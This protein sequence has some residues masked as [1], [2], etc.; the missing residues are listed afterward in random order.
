MNKILEQKMLTIADSLG[1][2]IAVKDEPFTLAG[3]GHKVVHYKGRNIPIRFMI[4]GTLLLPENNVGVVV[5][6]D[7]WDYNLLLY[8]KEDTIYLV[9]YTGKINCK[10]YLGKTELEL[11]SLNDIIGISKRPFNDD[12]WTPVV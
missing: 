10:L 9:L 2:D 8:T 7:N 1:V 4:T 5:A 12:N 3:T 11:S 6:I